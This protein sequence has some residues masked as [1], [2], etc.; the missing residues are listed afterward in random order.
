MVPLKAGVQA[1]LVRSTTASTPL[2]VEG[3]QKPGVLTKL[4]ARQAGDMSTSWSWSQYVPERVRNSILFEPMRNPSRRFE[5][6]GLTPRV[7]LNGAEFAKAPK[8]EKFL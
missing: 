5:T 6:A 1:A 8:V 4:L 3:L 7:R 2:S